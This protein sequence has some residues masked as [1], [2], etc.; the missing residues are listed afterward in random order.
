MKG[1][2]DYLLESGMPHFRQAHVGVESMKSDWYKDAKFGKIEVH[3]FF[4]WD[5]PSGNLT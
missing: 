1:Q 2:S 3:T 5:L 4:W